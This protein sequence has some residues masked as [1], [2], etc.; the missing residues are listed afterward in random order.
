VLESAVERKL[1]DGIRK[2]GGWAIKL[3][4]PGNSGVPDRLVLMP[5]GRVIFVELKTDT[6]RVSP[7]Q[8]QVHDRLRGMGMDVRV[9]YGIVAVREF[10]REVETDAL[11]ALPI[12]GSGDAVD[13]G[14]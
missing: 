14:A 5:G 2:A 13:Y 3:V 6:G 1:V 9:L 4:S 11:P 10:L 7:L 12:P 8:Q